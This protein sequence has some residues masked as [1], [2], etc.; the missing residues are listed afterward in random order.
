MC[1]VLC[2][3]YDARSVIPLFQNVLQLESAGGGPDTEAR[4]ALTRLHA[5]LQTLEAAK[6]GAFD[7]VD[8]SED[9]LTVASE[10]GALSIPQQMETLQGRVGN[11][12]RR[13]EQL[14]PGTKEILGG[15][16]GEWIDE[17]LH[18]T[19]SGGT[20]EVLI[21]GVGTEGQ[22]AAEAPVPPPMPPH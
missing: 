21:D 15:A 20:S 2:K 13:L 6:A 22:E 19:G 1:S 18:S 11:L 7:H 14:P 4:E 9:P 17:Q 16:A 12:E 8:P 5:S 3:I 10:T